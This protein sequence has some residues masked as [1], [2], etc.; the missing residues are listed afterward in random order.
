MTDE[1]I[2]LRGELAP[3]GILRAA[4]NFGNT[5]L[6]R[7]GATL[8]ESGGVSVA[9]ARELARR[10]DVPLELVPFDG[11]GAVVA[12]AK[13]D[14]FDVAFMAI[15]PLRAKDVGFTAPYVLIEGGYLVRNE[16]PLKSIEEVDRP[17]IR[18]TVGHGSAYDLFLTR[19]LKH[20]E[21][22]RETTSA[23]ALDVFMQGSFDVA[24]GVKASLADYAA[25]HAGVRLLDGR[26]MVIEQAMVTVHGLNAVRAISALIEELKR[27]GFVA[28]ELAKTGQGDAVVAP[29][30]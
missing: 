26:F 4:I 17:G 24:A 21:I 6:S 12:V 2:A 19:S 28:D 1:M 25:T 7:R 20:A 13:N 10:L 23:D 11:A 16:S 5:V 15:D 27:S 14:V 9:I 8:E 3:H 22:T 30:A 18:M 29:P